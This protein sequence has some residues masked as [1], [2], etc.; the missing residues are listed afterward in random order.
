MVEN[1][2]LPVTVKIR[3][4]WDAGSVNYR[5]T[6]AAACEAGAAMVCLHSRTRAQGYSG[7]ADWAHIRDLKERSSVPVFGSGDI[8]TAGDAVRMLKETL[9]DG[10]MF[11]RGAMGNPFIFRE[12][13]SLLEAGFAGLSSAPS[14]EERLRAG[15]SHLERSIRYK[16]EAL[17]C[18]EMRKHFTSYAKGIP[19]GSRLR[20][21]LVR[22][23]S[24]EEY[25]ELVEEFIGGAGGAL[26]STP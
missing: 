18:R 26:L 9:C 10:V 19:G 12:T 4:G 16:G 22:A 13:K 6:A 25:V 2:S 3:S 20:A 21:S 17:A 11:A 5:E 7:S 8:F 24:R 1:S 15:L 14:P 23:S